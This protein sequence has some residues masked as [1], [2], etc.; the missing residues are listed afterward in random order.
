MSYRDPRQL[1]QPVP[2]TNEVVVVFPFDEAKKEFDK[3]VYAPIMT[4]NRLSQQ[5]VTNFFQ[6][7]Y[8]S[9][10][11]FK[12]LKWSASDILFFVMAFILDISIFIFSIDLLATPEDYAYEDPDFESFVSLVGTFCLL[13][14]ILLYILLI[15]KCNQKKTHHQQKVREQMNDVLNQNNPY[16]ANM[17]LRWRLPANTHRW[18]ELWLDFKYANGMNNNNCITT[19]NKQLTQTVNST[20]YQPPGLNQ[21]GYNVPQQNYGA[22]NLNAFYPTFQKSPSDCITV[23]LN[24]RFE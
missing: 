1:I 20:A 4:H 21:A 22:T 3:S 8:H 6:Q 13:F 2:Q 23:P 11:W 14:S 17:G 10:N 5:D 19:G 16:F 24:Q 18:V 9:T 12:N 7:L 15:V